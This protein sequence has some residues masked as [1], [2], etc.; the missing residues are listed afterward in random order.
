MIRALRRKFILVAML[1]TFV[2]LAAIMGTVNVV[3]YLRMADRADG[4]TALLAQNDGKFPGSPEMERKK[5]IGEE[6]IK[7]DPEM[8]TPNLIPQKVKEFPGTMKPENLSPETPYET[9]FFFVIL[10]SEGNLVS[11]NT[12]CIAAVDEDAALEYAAG[13]SSKRKDV[14][15]EGIYRYR[16]VEE[17]EN[18]RYIFLDCRKDI[19]SF[20]NLLIIS[21]SV[22]VLGLTAVFFL[23]VFFSRFVFQP[24]AESLE[25]QK[26][27]ITDA[28]HE[29]KTPLT[30]IDANTEVMEMEHGESQWTKSTRKQIRRLSVLTQQLVTLARLDEERG[31]EER[32][33]F[34]LSDAVADSIRPFEAPVRTQGKRLEQQIE[35]GIS[36]TGN[37][38]S[39][40]QMMGILLDNAVKYSTECGFIR[41]NLTRRGKKIHLEVFNE[42]EGLP[43]GKLDI[44]FERFYRLDTSRNSDTGG[45]GIGLSVAKAI[46]QAHKGKINAY[47]EDGK[48]L[49][50]TV[51]F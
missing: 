50:I 44:L 3:N 12:E 36:Y 29:L 35:E 46:V 22:S 2:V 26:Q 8:E 41:V 7:A 9:R 5:E 37:E 20:R 42:A 19:E 14:G 18:L 40:R 15:F 6:Q 45:S 28:S 38:K 10:D 23:V 31:N 11:S 49:T 13:I 25:K 27:F 34:S 39:I 4:M 17:A 16:I 47:S 43:E 51:V 30:I 1:S 48:S 33:E 24:V 32:T 21:S